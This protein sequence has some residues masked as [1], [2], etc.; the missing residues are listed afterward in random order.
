MAEPLSPWLTRPTLGSHHSHKMEP[1]QTW[2][3]SCKVAQS[4]DHPTR[5]SCSLEKHEF[6]DIFGTEQLQSSTDYIDL[7]PSICNLDLAVDDLD[8]DFVQSLINVQST[9][10]TLEFPESLVDTPRTLP[11]IEIR[12]MTPPPSPP[13]HTSIPRKC[14][15]FAHAN[16]GKHRRAKIFESEEDVVRKLP[17][18][19]LYL[20]RRSFNEWDKE[21]KLRE[22]L[23]KSEL[24]FLSRTRR[25]YL[26]R[27][28]AK[29][30]REKLKMEKLESAIQQTA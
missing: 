9:D 24:R 1:A 26:S 18:E 28:Y 22:K 2:G 23:S 15:S 4:A 29:R 20:D 6:H 27:K 11:K 17:V 7:A 12:G 30:R 10:P 3:V 14:Q 19:V 13:Q 16:A 8:M 25:K 5:T 21:C